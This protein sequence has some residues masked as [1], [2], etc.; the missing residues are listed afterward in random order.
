MK[1]ELVFNG[2]PSFFVDSTATIQ[3]EMKKTLLSTAAISMLMVC[4]KN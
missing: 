1:H 4:Q 2:Y 3:P